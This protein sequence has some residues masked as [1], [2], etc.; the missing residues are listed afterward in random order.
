MMDYL[1]SQQTNI[2]Y[3]TPK[4]GG[5]IWILIIVCVCDRIIAAGEKKIHFFRGDKM[6]E[7]FDSDVA[8]T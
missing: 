3:L 1:G 2:K 8:L 5:K 4:L 6:D 7:L